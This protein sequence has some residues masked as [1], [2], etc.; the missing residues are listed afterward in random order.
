MWLVHN[1]HTLYSQHVEQPQTYWYILIHLCNM[2]VS[3]SVLHCNNSMI[4]CYKSNDGTF[5][6]VQYPC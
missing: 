3:S 5:V 1:S 6:F 4:T 2:G